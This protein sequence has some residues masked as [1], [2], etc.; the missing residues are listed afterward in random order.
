M[1]L[2][3][4]RVSYPDESANPLVFKISGLEVGKVL[5]ANKKRETLEVSSGDRL[6]DSF[7]EP[8]E[9]WIYPK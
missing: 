2:G 4:V 1:T 3:P 7:G 8:V 6:P 5:V 9:L